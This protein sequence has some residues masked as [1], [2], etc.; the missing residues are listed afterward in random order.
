MQS[1][2]FQA[3]AEMSPRNS[4]WAVVDPESQKVHKINYN[5]QDVIYAC[6]EMY[7]EHIHNSHV[8]R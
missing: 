8:V 6:V 4:E 3:K 5:N 2:S 7:P 1:L